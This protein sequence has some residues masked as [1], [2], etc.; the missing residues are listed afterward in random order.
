MSDF[1][2]LV[3]PQCGGALPQQAAWRRVAC[4]YCHVLV[5]RNPSL[6]ERSH[7]QAALRRQAAEHARLNP[8][9]VLEGAPCRLIAPLGSGET[10]SIWQAERLT[11]YPER[12]TLKIAHDASG[13]AQLDAEAQH[14]QNLLARD[15][16]GSAY[17]SRRIPQLVAQ[18]QY[19]GRRVLAWRVPPGY[20]GSMAAVLRNQPAGIRSEHAVWIWRRVLDILGYLHNNGLAHGALSADH[21]LVQPR[22]HGVMLIGWRHL[23]SA[24]PTDAAHDLQ[25]SAWTIR[26]LLNPSDTEPPA[27]RADLPAPLAD[28]LASASDYAWCRST[29]APALD[30]LLKDRARQA[31]GPPRFIPFSPHSPTHF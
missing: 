2:A 21:W 13:A 23:H 18:G 12:I 16:P 25:Q 28:L 29:T 31:F 20:W 14:L 8:E 3:C 4:T 17:Y 26:Q 15:G 30:A 22:D 10:A 9:F 24:E 7:F 11:A 6:V 19:Q 1:L 27:L 5:T